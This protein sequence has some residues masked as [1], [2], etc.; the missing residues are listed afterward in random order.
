M[1]GWPT[2]SVSEAMPDVSEAAEPTTAPTRRGM[3]RK[4]QIVAAATDLFH[5]NGYYA[6]GIDDIGAAAGITGPGI[7]RHFASKDDIL[8]E[9][10]D[11][12]WLT[13]RDSVNAAQG[14][15]P[16]EALDLMVA[17][18]VDLV[19]DH[20]AATTLFLKELGSL[21]QEYQAKVRRN[22][23]TYQDAWARAIKGRSPELTMDEARIVARSCFWAINAYD[24]DPAADRLSRR[25]AKE[26]LTSL[27][28]ALLGAL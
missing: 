12:I 18:H 2:R 14:L 21:P 7:Y 1:I 16:Q 8:M 5:R 11:R 22:D 25:R 6:T 20:R 24:A 17:T 3:E 13:L 26:I 27:A 15:S 23:A 10:F 4:E 9:V 19:V 28:G